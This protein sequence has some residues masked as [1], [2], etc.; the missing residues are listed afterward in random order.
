MLLAYEDNILD[1]ISDIR[2]S[3]ND[4]ILTYAGQIGYSV[5]PSFRGK[6]YANKILELASKEA[7]NHYFNRMLFTCNEPN[8]TSSKVIERNGGILGKIILHSAFPNVKRYLI[9]L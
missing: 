1:G 2:L 8:I 3:T 4:F 7:A 5:R 9:N 6:G